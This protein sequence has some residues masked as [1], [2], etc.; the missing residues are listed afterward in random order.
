LIALAI[1]TTHAS[2]SA[3]RWTMFNVA[4]KVGQADCHLLQFPDGS[5][6]LIDVADG[7]DVPGAA[8]AHLNKFHIHRLS[9]VIIS[10]FHKDHYGRLI[11]ILN[12]GLQVDRVVLNVP[13]KKSADR[14]IPW[15]CDWNDVQATLGELRNRGIPFTTPKTGDRIFETK[16]KDGIGAG[17]DVICCFDG[18]NTPVGP[19]DVNDTS[20]VL[21]LS[22][23]KERLLF[24]GDLNNAIGSYLVK[25][26]TD[27]TADLLKAPHHGIDST[28]P[29][30]FYDRVGANA[31]LVPSPKALWQSA[32]SM[33]TRDYFIEHHV[34]TY[35]SGINGDITVT[36]TKN[37]Y[38]VYSEH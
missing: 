38:T 28:V 1:N 17:I 26:A 29:N 16:S 9:L 8:L 27:L 22:Y 32:R 11:D 15:G 20:I 6:I 34:P 31:V 2:E 12:A 14:E 10:H 3:V 19:T 24:T 4:G 18:L 33:R 21:R 7:V 30:A 5:N 36:I 25:S 35:V 37:A 23:G 13:D